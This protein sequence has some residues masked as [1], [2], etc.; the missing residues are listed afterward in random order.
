M[1]NLIDQYSQGAQ[2]LARA[3]AGMTPAQLRA[4]PIPGKWST[5]TVVIHL[6]DAELSFADRMR[7]I[8]AMDG[9]QLLAWDENAFLAQLHYETQSAD[10]AVQII[11]L[12]RRQ[13]TRIL[14]VLPPAAFTRV[15]QHSERGPQT[16]ETVIGFANK[17]LEHHL[18]FIA[19]KRELLEKEVADQS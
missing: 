16:L 18:K 14:K 5:H 4:M 13:M 1:T 17:H 3:I 19:E 15:G 9:A 11:E 7:R 2:K 12:T 6:A 8:I 10:D